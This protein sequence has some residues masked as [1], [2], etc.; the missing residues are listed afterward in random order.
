MAAPTKRY[1]W[2]KLK[3]DFF[4]GMYQRK[5]RKQ[6]NGELLLIIYLKMMLATCDS[7]GRFYYQGVFEDIA[8]EIA[9]TIVEDPEDVRNALDYFENNGLV[10]LSA[11]E[12]YTP[13]VMNCVGS[14]CESAERVRKHRENT[15]ALQCN[16]DVTESNAHVTGCNTEKEIDKRIDKDIELDKD[17]SHMFNTTSV[18]TVR[19]DDYYFNAPQYDDPPFK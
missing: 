17:K 9:E 3:K 4:S 14:E 15:K 11:D 13:E 1:Y 16:N 5:M 7:E 10:E 8:T 19:R 18:S 6:P 2:I 12:C